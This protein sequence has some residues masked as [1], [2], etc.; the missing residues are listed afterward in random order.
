MKGGIRYSV[1]Y[2]PDIPDRGAG[3]SSQLGICRIFAIL[4]SQSFRERRSRMRYNDCDR[5]GKD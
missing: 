2:V 5:T 1:A 3:F 4:R